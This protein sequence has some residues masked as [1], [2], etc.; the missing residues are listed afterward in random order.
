MVVTNFQ[1]RIIHFID[2]RERGGLM[3]LLKTFLFISC[4]SFILFITA[5]AQAV[6]GVS[7]THR[8]L[9]ADDLDEGGSVARYFN[10]VESSGNVF[11]IWRAVDIDQPIKVAPTCQRHFISLNEA[12]GLI[13]HTMLAEP[14]RYV[15]NSGHLLKMGDIAERLYPGRKKEIISPRR[16]D[17]LT[18]KFLATS[19]DI[20]SYNLGTA[21]IKVKNIHDKI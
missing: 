5:T 14:G 2:F 10:V 4:V 1:L 19:E 15:V 9:M 6:D 13:F 11:E 8:F 3:K 12:T 20:E 7:V 18:E 21:I 16:G 17:R